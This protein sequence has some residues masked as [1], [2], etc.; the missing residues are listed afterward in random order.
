MKIEHPENEDPISAIE[1]S[2][3]V[4]LKNLRKGINEKDEAFVRETIDA[5]WRGVNRGDARHHAPPSADIIKSIIEHEYAEIGVGSGTKGERIFIKRGELF[6]NEQLD[7]P[8]SLPL[9]RNF[10]YFFELEDDAPLSVVF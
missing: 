4:Y 9:S 2:D 5:I 7:Q 3:N 1:R 8:N 10:R 6:M